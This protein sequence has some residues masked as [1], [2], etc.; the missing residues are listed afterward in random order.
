MFDLPRDAMPSAW[1]LHTLPGDQPG[2]TMPASSRDEESAHGTPTP[3]WD[4]HSRH[5]AGRRGVYPVRPAPDGPRDERP[6]GRG[7]RHGV[8]GQRLGPVN[9]AVREGRDGAGR[10]NAPARPATECHNGRRLPVRLLYPLWVGAAA[11]GQP[12]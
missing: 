4:G 3:Q 9:P 12:G 6:D 2:G 7:H 8:G 5:G 10:P 11:T 1:T